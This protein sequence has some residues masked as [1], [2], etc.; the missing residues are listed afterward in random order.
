[1][2]CEFTSAEH[3]EAAAANFW[4]GRVLAAGGAIFALETFAIPRKIRRRFVRSQKKYHQGRGEA[5][6][7][8]LHFVLACEY[9]K[10]AGK[11]VDD[12]IAVPRERVLQQRLLTRASY[13]VRRS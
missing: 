5:E 7:E 10:Q 6:M 12:F 4:I 9:L 8:M 13:R 2:L 1:M 11:V 3:F